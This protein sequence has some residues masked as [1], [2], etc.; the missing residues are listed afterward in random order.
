MMLIKRWLPIIPLYSRLPSVKQVY[1][2]KIQA[3]F[4]ENL[5]YSGILLL[6]KA[7]GLTGSTALSAEPAAAAQPAQSKA[8]IDSKTTAAD[9]HRLPINT[10]RAL[11]ELVTQ[12]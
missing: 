5:I 11:W 12:T 3:D 10:K 8:R 7:C 2:A 6:S 4:Q 1:C 9:G